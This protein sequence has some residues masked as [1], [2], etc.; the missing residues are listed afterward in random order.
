MDL[1]R[2]NEEKIQFESDHEL[3]HDIE[4]ELKVYSDFK[5]LF[6]KKLEISARNFET[7]KIAAVFEKTFIK[8]IQNS[9]LLEIMKTKVMQ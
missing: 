6:S 3:K 1:W 9:D 7:K 2:I 5:D 8:G 4:K